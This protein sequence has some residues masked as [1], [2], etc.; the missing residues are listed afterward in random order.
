M[1]ADP[2]LVEAI[3]LACLEPN[4]VDFRRV[5][6]WERLSGGSETPLGEV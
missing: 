2:K 5:A 1:P 3:I 6:A 4:P